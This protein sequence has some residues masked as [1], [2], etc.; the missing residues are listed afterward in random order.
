[1][2]RGRTGASN[3]N[4]AAQTEFD[5]LGVVEHGEQ[6]ARDQVIA[7]VVVVCVH[8]KP[9]VHERPSHHRHA[10]RRAR[11]FGRQ[12]R[13][14]LPPHLRKKSEEKRISAYEESPG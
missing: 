10:H 1:M 6:G 12:V 4:S 11:E 3:P 14:H 13:V 9:W 8:N 7:D 2:A 5:I